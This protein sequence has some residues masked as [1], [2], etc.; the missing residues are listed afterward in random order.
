MQLYC[1]LRGATNLCAAASIEQMECTK[2]SRL[3]SPA[4]SLVLLHCEGG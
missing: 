1:G 4:F 2:S 3:R